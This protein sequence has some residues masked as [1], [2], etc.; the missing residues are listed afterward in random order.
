MQ[1]APGPVPEGSMDETRNYLF[2]LLT[3]FSSDY[4]LSFPVDSKFLEDK[5]QELLCCIPMLFAHY[6]T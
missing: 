5:N 4:V 2:L 6:F 1:K 3:L